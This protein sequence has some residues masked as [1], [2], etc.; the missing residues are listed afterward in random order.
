MAASPFYFPS[1]KRMGS[2]DPPGLQNRRT[3]GFPVVGAF[4]SHTLP[5]LPFT[6]HST[7][8][9][10]SRLRRCTGSLPARHRR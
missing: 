3:A 2:G 10:L 8:M 9:S 1:R 4:D 7:Y 6:S 5:P